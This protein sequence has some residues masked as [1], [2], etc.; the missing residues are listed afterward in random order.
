LPAKSGDPRLFV[1]FVGR[2]LRPVGTRCEDLR[3]LLSYRTESSGLTLGCGMDHLWASACRFTAESTCDD[4]F[5]A[6]VFKG[7]IGC[8][9]SIRVH[10][11]LSYHYGES[12]TPQQIRSQTAWTLDRAIADG[13][14]RIGPSMSSDPARRSMKGRCS[15]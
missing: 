11:F 7:V 15:R 6:T 8:G 4:D 13:F 1:G 10:K 3:A 14:T 2:V 9:K 5:A 12:A